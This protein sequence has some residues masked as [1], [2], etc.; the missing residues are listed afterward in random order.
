MRTILNSFAVL[1]GGRPY[2]EKGESHPNN[3]NGSKINIKKVIPSG[4]NIVTS[5][6]NYIINLIKS[7][8]TPTTHEIIWTLNQCGFDENTL[9]TFNFNDLHSALGYFDGTNYQYV[10]FYMNGLDHEKD[11]S[12]ADFI[13]HV[14]ADACQFQSLVKSDDI[15]AF[16]EI[17]PN[18]FDK[19]V[20]DLKA[21]DKK[22]KLLTNNC[23]KAVLEVVNGCIG[24]EYKIRD[25]KILL[26]SQ[27]HAA[28]KNMKENKYGVITNDICLLSEEDEELDED[29]LALQP[30]IPNSIRPPP[31]LP[32]RPMHLSVAER[33][34]NYK[35]NKSRELS[36]KF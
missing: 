6:V 10:S 25:S 36:T 1:G 12:F 14:Y 13:R 30:L 34:K 32:K 21:K 35:T 22:Y 18:I 27:V 26:P 28:L 33:L 11:L 19:S 16:G 29:N 9:C 7:G 23:S 20:S 2:I 4:E 5:T 31:P 17:G 8:N 3:K 24:G 15:H